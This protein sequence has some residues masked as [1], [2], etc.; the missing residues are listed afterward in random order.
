MRVFVTG[1][2][3]FVGRVVVPELLG[4]G[5][6]VAG[7]ARSDKS[8]AALEAAGAEVHRGSL[9]DLESLRSGAAAADG[10]IHLA[11]NHDDFADFAANAAQDRRAIEVLG[12]AL[13]GSG[14][15][16]VITS[17]TAGA[18]PGEIA[19]EDSMPDPASAASPRFGT[20]TTALAFADRGVR[21]SVVRL[22]PSVHGE[23]D[24]G[25]VPQV[26]AAARAKGVSA[27]PG[28]GAQRWPAVH[29]L[30]AAR[31]F[32]LALES[33]SAGTRLH[34]VG[35]EGVPIRE[36]AEV[37]GRHLGVPVTSIAP[38]AAYDHF[39]FVGAALALDIPASAERTR[40]ELGWQPEQPGLVADLEA[41]HY[42]AEVAQ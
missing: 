40:K 17:G 5:H 33:A 29:R 15:P 27:H 19:T 3:G 39:G 31:V 36:V 11:F 22:P 23:G 28:D 14:R 21:V 20:E 26:I 24:K 32:R 16:L 30:D 12:D 18:A 9:D 8:A 41:G 38:E 2:T 34:A 10:V 7:L 42:F 37:I 4:A 25:F 6:R 35:D 1:A 13:A